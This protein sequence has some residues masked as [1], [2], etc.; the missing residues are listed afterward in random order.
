M[1]ADPENQTEEIQFQENS[2][3]FSASLMIH[4]DK[5]KQVQRTRL[6]LSEEQVFRMPSS[7]L[8]KCSQVFK[9]KNEILYCVSTQ[10]MSVDITD[11]SGHTY[12][13]LLVKEDVNK[14]LLRLDPSLRSKISVIHLGAVKIMLKAYFRDGINTPVKMALVDDRI[15][16]RKDALLG[17]ARGNLAYGKFI[18]TV[19]PKYGIALNTAN[20]D[21][22]LSFY[23]Q[24]E[25]D[26]LMNKGDKVFSITY[27]V[28]YALSNSHHSIDYRSNSS[29]EL[30]DV[31]SDIGTVQDTPFAELSPTDDSWILN[32]QRNKTL[33]NSKSTRINSGNLHVGRNIRDVNIANGINESSSKPELLRDISQKIDSLG[34]QLKRIHNE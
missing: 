13:P 33:V 32:I 1:F 29:I 19:Y 15:N 5:L 11:V 7:L 31:F 27:L 21:K 28:G 23:H 18:F 24:F 3:G 34:E 2:N 26:D 30:E 6:S 9:R 25:Y 10:E 20:L 17:A 14:K 22:A 16:N 12:L 8:N 4:N